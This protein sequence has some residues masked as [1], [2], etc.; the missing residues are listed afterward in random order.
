MDLLALKVWP[1]RHYLKKWSA[2]VAEA[3]DKEMQETIRTSTQTGRPLGNEKWVK[4]LE[5]KFRRRLHALPVG[6]PPKK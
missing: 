3:L 1:S 2:I 5:R 4:S 6:R